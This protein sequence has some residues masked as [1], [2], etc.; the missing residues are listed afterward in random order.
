MSNYLVLNLPGIV[1]SVEG[2]RANTVNK[3]LCPCG[4][5]ILGDRGGVESKKRK[6]VKYM[7]Y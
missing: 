3:D 6:E 4:V 1:L 2:K 7:V 5:D